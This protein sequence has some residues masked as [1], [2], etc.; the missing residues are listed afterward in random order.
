MQ[1]YL[2]LLIDFASVVFPFAF[3]FYPKANFSKKWK[4]L[5]P[6]LFTGA[7][8]FLAWDIWFTDLGV[9][10]FNPN[11]LCGLYFFNLPVEEV[12]FFFCIPYACVFT[13]EAV[14]Y[15]SGK[16]FIFSQVQNFIT[17][18]LIFGLLITAT[19]NHN[20]WYTSVTFFSTAGFLILLRRIWDAEFLGRF[21]FAFLFILIPFFL[22]NGILTGTGIDSPVVWYN[23]AENLGLRMGSIPVEDTF[24]GMLLLLINVSV[25]EF[26]QKRKSIPTIQDAFK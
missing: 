4:F 25:F 15:L 14:N 6:A 12:L 3:S 10:G 20:H 22:V 19:L 13:Y 23:N 9:W 8:P 17:D 18:V 26:L 24:Y 16:K 2:Y 7:I 21:Y 11:Y 1:H 5:V